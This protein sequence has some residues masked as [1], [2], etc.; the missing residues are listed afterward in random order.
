M[1]NRHTKARS[2]ALGVLRFSSLMLAGTAIIAIATPAA[3][4]NRWDGSESTDYEDPANWEQ[5]A[6][7]GA[8]SAA[9]IDT[10]TNAP[11]VTTGQI[12]RAG[13][14]RVGVAGEGALT[15]RDGGQLILGDSANG[16]LLSVGGSRV[17]SVAGGIGTLLVTGQNSGVSGASGLAFEVGVGPSSVGTVRIEDGAELFTSTGLIGSE[18]TATG[19]VTITGAGS[20]WEFT[21]GAGGVRIGSLN[22]DTAN[23]TLNVLDGGRVFF[24]DGVGWTVGSGGTINVDGAGSS[25][26]IDT[27]IQSRG[28]INITGGGR[29]QV[30][31]MIGQLGAALRVSGADSRFTTGLFLMGQAENATGGSLVVEDGGQLSSLGFGIAS[32]GASADFDVTIQGEGTLWTINPGNSRILGAGTNQVDFRVLDGAVVNDAA[33]SGNWS[34]GQGTSV[35]VSG[36]GSRLL[37]S[38][39][40]NFNATAIGQPVGDIIVE[41]GG[42]MTVNANGLSALGSLGGPVSRSLVVRSGGQVNFIGGSGA[43]LSVRNGSI[44]VDGGTLTG[45][46]E[47]SGEADR[48]TTV[49][50]QGGGLID[51]TGGGN[52]SADPETDFIVTGENSRLIAVGA[53]VV[54][55]DITV[56]AGGNAS[57]QAID[58]GSIS[59]TNSL[60]VSGPGSQFSSGDFFVSRFTDFNTN[61]LVED[62][63]RLITGRVLAGA[64]SNNSVINLTV[65]G[66][67]S[68]WQVTSGAT[69][70][71]FGAGASD[72]NLS[73]L[74]GGTFQSLSAINPS[75]RANTDLLISGAGSTFDTAGNISF[76]GAGIGQ[77]VGTLVV[78]NGG[79][80]IT[81]GPSDNGL[82]F[83]GVLRTME[84]TGGSSWIMTGGANSGLQIETTNLLVEDSTLSAEGA[85]SIGLRFSGTD[86]ILRNSDFTARALNVGSVG[87][88]KVTLGTRADG[89][90]GGVGQFNVGSVSLTGGN[91]LEINHTATDFV[92]GSTITGAGTITHLA[93]NSRFSGGQAGFSGLFEVTGGNVAI[94]GALGGI[95]ARATFDNAV[96]SGTGSFGGDVTLGN[97]TLAPGNSAGTFTIGGDLVLGA[98]SLL[99]FELGLPDQAPGV[100]SDLIVVGGDLTLDGTLNISDI[101]GFGGGLYRLINYGGSLT[102]NGLEFGTLPA[103]FDATGLTLNLAAAGQV[104]LVVTAPDTD[105]IFW[106]GTQTS[107]NG[108]ADGGSGTW[109]VAGSNW[110]N[111]AADRNGAFDP[112]DFLIFA[113][114]SS[115]AAASTVTVDNAGGQVT[116]ANG[117]QFAADGYTIGGG[118]IGLADGNIVVRVGDGT[119]AGRGFTTTFTSALTGTSRLVKTDLGTLVLGGTNTYTGGTSVESGTLVGNSTSLQGFISVNSLTARVVFD[120]DFDGTYSG[121]FFSLGTLEKTGSGV[122]T[123]SGTSGFARV[124]SLLEGGL[125]VTGTLGNSGVT[126]AGVLTTAAGTTLTGDGTINALNVGGI[127]APGAGSAPSVATLTVPGSLVFD[128]GSTYRVDLAA[129]GS[130]DR[131]VAASID[132]SVTING[133]TVAIN[134]LDPELDYVDGTVFTII[135]TD[136]SLTGTFDGLIEN[137][138]FLDFTLGYD[139]NRAFLTLDVVR[140]FPD[141]ALTF[142]QRQASL[143]LMDLDRT[144]GSD[145]LAVYNAILFLNE[146]QA[147]DAFDLASGEIYADLL[148]TGNRAIAARN[149]G[150]VTGLGE[151]GREGWDAWISGGVTD[152]RVSDDGNGARTTL[153]EL[154]VELGLDYHGADNRWAVGLSGGWTRSDVDNTARGSGAELDGW[155][156]SGFARYGDFG[157]G[158][159]LAVAASHSDQEGTASRSMAFGPLAREA[160]AAVDLASTAITGQI[161][162]GL[163]SDRLA[164][165]PSVTVEYADTSLGSYAEYGAGAL[166]LTGT[167]ASDG[168]TRLGGG[169][170][171]AFNSDRTNLQLDVQYLTGSEDDSSVFHSMDGSPQIFEVRP[172]RGNGDLVRLAGQFETRFGE[173]ASVTL[174]G[175]ALLGDEETAVSG[176]ASLRIAF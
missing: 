120:Q 69:A 3:A 66:T 48:R 75:F 52:W 142:N 103:G 19:T 122:L 83:N 121:D 99:D 21:S 36:A 100:G 51:G 49:T 154:Q 165:G 131:I 29:A 79:T 74:N 145:S 132:G 35:L 138:A 163:G 130:S 140:T 24:P 55:G 58:L 39:V 127:V 98:T 118:S 70:L 23:G 139:A 151:R 46:L 54:G 82:G 94:D 38:G 134:L 11:V 116:L 18:P 57:F 105:F 45:R 166:N 53:P 78:E 176:T 133:G 20:L 162:Y 89:S 40:V 160:N 124:N 88:N 149:Y 152:L 34:V 77:P 158:L 14:L 168:W 109:S 119:E 101:G 87:G 2:H 174:G 107:A 10:T 95:A 111:L 9:Q 50:V 112:T 7:P 106:D 86:L 22:S 155:F 104:N 153:D 76:G 63:G 102:D 41:Q 175:Q 173:R 170:F 91:L 28:T 68:L 169:A 17:L 72:V 47:L 4:Q 144:Q 148:A 141:V 137:S 67:D 31:D 93:G 60:T 64:N 13:T 65:T 113:A 126:A 1:T 136:R 32:N 27:A 81:R 96:L 5:N 8:L 159:T 147:R 114:P 146:D 164:F 6:V 25:L 171:V 110:T 108:V 43:G 115:G 157:K 129:D 12:A 16:G 172:A 71:D 42:E 156:V 56:T 62:G 30:Q 128:P 84:I 135:Q 161:R 37:T 97:A 44:L 26:L 33:P 61:V 125:N 59:R 15:V 167:G 92:I 90:A 73:I 150:R 80:L 143:G 85:V 123:I 117:V